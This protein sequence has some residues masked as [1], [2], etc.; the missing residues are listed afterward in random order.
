MDPVFVLYFVDV[1]Y[2]F[3]IVHLRDVKIQEFME[4]TEDYY[5]NLG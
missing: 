2:A 5:I 3:S 4:S 1:I